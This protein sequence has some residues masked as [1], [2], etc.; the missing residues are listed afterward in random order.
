[1][2]KISTYNTYQSEVYKNTLKKKENDVK[3]GKKNKADK[4][5]NAS[6]PE[7]SDKAKA[8]LEELKKK[9][10]NIDFFVA[11][12][13]SEEEAAAYLNRGNK[14]YSVLIDSETLE[15]M[16]ADDSVK[17]KYTDIIDNATGQ[18]SEMKEKLGEDGEEV[19]R[20]GVIVNND[21]TVSYFAELEKMSEKQRERI[22][23]AREEKREEAAEEKKK[24]AKEARELPK[25]NAAFEKTKKTTLKADSIGELIE[26]IKNVDWSKVEEE[27][28]PVQGSRFDFSI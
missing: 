16:A 1:M 7:L 9:Y 3:A 28:I 20:I 4:V 8:L 23:K 26:R 14:E 5:Q 21:G 25:D 22:E 27:E 19:T 18:L 10:S 6:Q 12:Y 2:N 13:S 24:A 15:E 11:D 17:E